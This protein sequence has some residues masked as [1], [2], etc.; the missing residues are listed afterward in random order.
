[1]V[2]YVADGKTII[3]KTNTTIRTKNVMCVVM[4]DNLHITYWFE[5]DQLL[6]L[7]RAWILVAYSIYHIPWSQ[8]FFVCLRMRTISMCP[9][10]WNGIVFSKTGRTR[11]FLINLHLCVSLLLCTDVMHHQV[12]AHL[13][14]MRASSWPIIILLLIHYHIIT[15]KCWWFKIYS[16]LSPETTRTGPASVHVLFVIFICLYF[17]TLWKT[18][19]WHQAFVPVST[20]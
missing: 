12:W 7:Y 13:L 17:K 18:W 16:S 19:S 8:D 20:I 15:L 6:A 4:C 2:Q 9:K 5:S 3:F 11:R 10:I 14:S 1:M